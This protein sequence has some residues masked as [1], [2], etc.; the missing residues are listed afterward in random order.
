MPHLLLIEDN[1]HIQ[2]VYREKFTHEGFDVT[3]ANDGEQGLTSAR[4][5]MPGIIL[6]DI[7]LPKLSGFD[8]LKQLR[9]DPQ[10]SRIPV[11]MLSNKS[12]PD[13]VQHALSLGARQFYAKGSSSLQDIITQIRADCAFKKAIIISQPADSAKAI[14]TT[15]RH[16]QLLCSSVTVLAETVAAVQRGAPDLIIFDTRPPANTNA[17]TIFQQ[18]K[19][20]PAIHAV[21]IISI[22]D[23][24]QMFARAE[25]TVSAAQIDTALRS[26][27]LKLIHLTEPAPADSTASLIVH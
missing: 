22:T 13:D 18:L 25:A 27:V 21:P 23:Q 2:R 16:P 9:D 6:L 5:T 8:V 14:R 10:L 11:F 19:S 26:T 20:V 4:E 3:V 24:P 1:Q 7:M 17:L 12:W 15:I